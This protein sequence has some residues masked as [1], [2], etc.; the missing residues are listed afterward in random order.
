VGGEVAGGRS[1]LTQIRCVSV[2]LAAPGFTAG[3]VMLVPKIAEV[4]AARIRSQ[5]VRGELRDGDGSTTA[6]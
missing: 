6:N 4:V 3:A 1:F 2:P 5:I